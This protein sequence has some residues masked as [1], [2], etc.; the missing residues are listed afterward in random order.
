[1]KPEIDLSAAMSHATADPDWVRKSVV[2]GLYFFLPFVGPFVL[3]GWQKRLVE[4]ALTHSEIPPVELGPDLVEGLR[5]F[6]ALLVTMA[7]IIAILL[8]VQ[9]AGI[10]PAL[11]L[12]PMEN[13]AARTVLVLATS[14]LTLGG[15]AV[16]MVLML[17][18]QLLMPDLLRRIFRG[19]LAPVLSLGRSIDAIRR[20]PTPYVVAFV[21]I[22]LAQIVGSLGTFA[23]FVGLVLTYPLSLLILA[24]VLAQWDRIASTPTT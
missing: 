9:C 18:Y 11:A 8:A 14:L 22:M 15:M 5:V 13:E 6:L 10:V 23:C 3:L 17:G 24:H 21:G 7:P 1:M 20:Q 19:E 16:F 12:E 2:A 4:Q